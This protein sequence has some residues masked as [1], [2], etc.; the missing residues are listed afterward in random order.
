MQSEQR[1]F[2]ARAD[3]RQYTRGRGFRLQ[4]RYNAPIDQ[5]QQVTMYATRI[6]PALALAA[7]LIP[8]AVHGERIYKWVDEDN[9]TVYSDTPPPRGAGAERVQGAPPP[10]VDPEAA[11]DSLR[12]R[13]EGFEER[14]E[15]RLETENKSEQEAEQA[16]RQREICKKLRANL[17]VLETN[18]RVREQKDGEEGASVLSEE[19]RRARMETTRKRIAEECAGGN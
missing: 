6:F 15:A 1:C 13:A 7:A 2:S 14:R 3:C 9:N 12:E 18:P 17:Q 10:P 16:R 4:V 11:M 8:P 5:E 19:Q